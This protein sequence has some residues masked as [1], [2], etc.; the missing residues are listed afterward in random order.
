[1]TKDAIAEFYR[2]N[3]H[4]VS[5]P[6]GGV[7]GFDAGL[8]REVFDQLEVSLDG[9]RVLDIG[10]GRGFLRE[11]V[12]AGGGRYI[13]LDLVA[14]AGPGRVLAA[15]AA[16]LPIADDAVDLGVCIDAYEHFPDPDA[17]AR[18]I[19]RVLVPGGVFFLSAPNYANVA[20]VVKKTYEFTG[21]YE[22]NTWAPFGRWQ[23]QELEQFITPGRV[24]R[25]FER[26]GFDGFRHI[27]FA[28][29]AGLGLFP[30]IDH[31]RM[32]DRIRFRLQ[33]M[34]ARVGGG[35]VRVWPGASLHCFYRMTA[36][37]T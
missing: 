30:W 36:P 32:P 2:E 6:F 4:M 14:N 27:G 17:V 28:R 26:A 12:E 37:E 20:G 16:R 23:P 10:C 8:L 29:E 11:I 31:P 7:D 13:G 9:R 21:L 3:P 1:M 19:C 35:I 5:S 22:R 18:E 34:F 33:R 24:R 25:R 15:D